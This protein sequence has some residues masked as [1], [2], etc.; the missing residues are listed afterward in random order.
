MKVKGK[1]I[2]VLFALLCFST[3]SQIVHCDIPPEAKLV[4]TPEYST[5]TTGVYITVTVDIVNAY[6]VYSYQFYMN[7][8]I[9]ILNVTS[10]TQ[11]PFLSKNGKY[12]TSFV[13]KKNNTEGYLLVGCTQSTGDFTT[14]QSGNGTLANITFLVETTGSTTL[15]LYNT[16]VKDFYGTAYTH[17]TDD[18]Y[19]SNEIHEVNV[20]SYLFNV[21]TRSNSTVYN[22]SLDTL[23][24][25]I[26]FNVL[27]TGD[28]FCNVSIPKDLMSAYPAW[29]ITIDGIPISSFSENTNETH[30]FLYFTYVASTHII[31]VIGTN[32]VPEF[33]SLIPV[34]ALTAALL[35][36]LAK[37]VHAKTRRFR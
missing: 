27:G 2:L 37:K 14:A 25:K 22:F 26:V 17:S 5:T 8:S 4:V 29:V 3:L 34:I 11:G 33:P 12:S 30:T 18:G 19:F 20:D 23:G 28:S 15:H 9:P 31:Q 21:I 35:A 32:I 36:L 1:L 24:T 16:K 6:N 10:I 13:Q 7:W